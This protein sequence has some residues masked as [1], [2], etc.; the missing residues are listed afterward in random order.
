M[1]VV[2]QVEEFSD[3]SKS[4][5][6]DCWQ[7]TKTFDEFY[8]LVQE[9]HLN[10]FTAQ[11]QQ[12]QSV[13]IKIANEVFEETTNQSAS[14]LQNPDDVKRLET[15]LTNENYIEGNN[16]LKSMKSNNSKS[17]FVLFHF[18][19]YKLFLFSDI[20]M[21]SKKKVREKLPNGQNGTENEFNKNGDF[22]TDKT[23]AA[24]AND[25]D[26]RI[27]EFFDMNCYL[28]D[29]KFNSWSEA[30]SH[31]PHKH[32]I[33][34]GYVICCGKKFYNKSGIIDHITFHINP[35]AFQ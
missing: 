7:R 33:V 9:A 29:Y 16:E 22:D 13:E 4:I 25:V 18:V 2:L 23:T 11:L 28:C 1:F 15:V 10:I 6:L 8:K 30:R 19:F 26:S 24:F 3:Y 5:C 27:H 14:I 21:R 20:R 17:D 32:N 34:K 12:S 31:Y 35:V